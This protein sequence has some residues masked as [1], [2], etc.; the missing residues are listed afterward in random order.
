M[1]Q[2]QTIDFRGCDKKRTARTGVTTAQ[3]IKCAEDAVDSGLVQ[4]AAVIVDGE[5]Y[6]EY[7]R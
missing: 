6:S 4:Y 5:V 1:I 3:V 2:L 7:E